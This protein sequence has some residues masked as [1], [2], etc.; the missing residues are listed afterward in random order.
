MKSSWSYYRYVDDILVICRA[1]QVDQIYD[2][3]KRI[4]GRNKLKCHP[5]NKEGSKS[6]TAPLTDGVEYLGF[7][8]HQSGVSIRESS[9]RKMFRTIG[10]VLTEF[11]FKK[12][13]ERL[14]WRLNLK[15]SGCTF[16]GKNFGWMFF[17]LQTDN[18][19]QLAR[20]DHFIYLQLRDRGLPRLRPQIKRFIRAYH[21]IRYNLF[22]TKY[23][24]N[25]DNYSVE[26]M[27]R[28]I[29]EVK[30][31]SLQ[32]L[33]SMGEEELKKTFFTMIGKEVGDLEKDLIEAFS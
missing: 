5:L 26:D 16:E 15:I 9:Y 7:K 24:P 18:M 10:S 12:S 29:N 20:L 22:D 33:N 30:G 21:E 3:L 6:Y 25:F 32:E 1:N 23:I 17:F 11:R 28:A 31:A 4:L 19:R 27:R 8:I 2:Q 14:V 13:E